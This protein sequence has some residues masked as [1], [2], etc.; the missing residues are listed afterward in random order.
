MTDERTPLR[1]ALDAHFEAEEAGGRCSCACGWETRAD[2]HHAAW[3]HHFEQAV[4]SAIEAEAS[5]SNATVAALD[6]ERLREAAR[7]ARL[8]WIVSVEDIEN[9]AREY[10]RLAADAPA[11]PVAGEGEADVED[12]LVDPPDS[13]IWAH[14]PTTS[15][16]AVPSTPPSQAWPSVE[17][18]EGLIE[19]IAVHVGSL[20]APTVADDVIAALGGKP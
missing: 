12:D 5:A 9:L 14:L 4:R 13:A 17:D 11:A 20:R 3:L 15:W 19:A 10:D 18:R 16:N 1:E 2:D 7:I 6:V 8:P